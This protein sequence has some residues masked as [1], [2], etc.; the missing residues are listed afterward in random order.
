M[1]KTAQLVVKFEKENYFL[2]LILM[3]IMIMLSTVGLFALPRVNIFLLGLPLFSTVAFIIVYFLKIS[4]Y[5]FIVFFSF[6]FLIGLVYSPFFM[7]YNGPAAILN[8]DGIWIKNYNFIYWEDIEEFSS[9]PVTGTLEAIG[10]QVGNVKKLSKQSNL[11]AKI[12]IFWSRVFGTP[13]ITLSNLD[14]ENEKIIIFAHRY[15]NQ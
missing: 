11:D 10:I 9:Y 1:S 2:G 7:G 6:G 5:F 14:T 3:P 13:H 4:L 15:L 8:K 12:R